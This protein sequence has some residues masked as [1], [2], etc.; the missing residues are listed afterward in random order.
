MRTVILP[1]MRILLLIVG[2]SCTLTGFGQLNELTEDQF[3]RLLLNNHPQILRAD[4]FQ[5]VGRQEVRAN[6][7]FFDPII[8]ADFYRKN[9]SNSIYYNKLDAGIMQPLSFL[10]MDLIGG[11]EV[12]NGNFLNPADNTPANGLVYAGVNLPLLQG[13]MIDRRRTDLA[14]SRIFRDQTNVEFIEAANNLLS[15]GLRS[16]WNWV[17]TLKRLEL[18]VGVLEN[19]REVFEGV[20]SAFLVGDRPAIDTVE[21]F[22]QLQTIT[23][24]YE[25]ELVRLQVARNDLERFLFDNEA[26]P[27]PLE[28]PDTDIP[29]ESAAAFRP[30]ILQL[31]TDE[32]WMQH[33]PTIQLLELEAKRLGVQTRWEREQL[34][35]RLDVNYNFLFN[36]NMT[37]L[38]QTF[39]SDNFQVGVGF[40]FPILMRR[41]LGRT[42]QFK[43]FQTQNQLMLTEEMTL[44]RNMYKANMYAYENLQEQVL[45]TERIVETARALYEAELRRF[46]LGESSVFLVNTREL[47]YLQVQ[48]NLI[49][50]KTEQILQSYQV[51]FDVGLLYKIAD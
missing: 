16:Y 44:L 25:Q 36:T 4:L 10:G 14:V 31:L 37:P 33:H 50:L 29:F 40:S 20:K 48:N 41:A 1:N 7:G 18:I 47:Q 35:P 22:Q 42:E 27:V 51:A 17:K 9:F 24:Q 12:N 21:S 15:N 45:I 43:I 11:V 28:S 19:N 2:L 26:Q 6:L 38:E 32:D 5:E 34:K 39:L 3:I 46:G 8:G 49:E 23:L 30:A 13:M